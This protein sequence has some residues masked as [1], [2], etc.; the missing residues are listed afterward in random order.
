MK[1]GASP[2]ILTNALANFDRAA[3]LLK[4][5][6]GADLLAV[7]REPKE[8]IELSMGPQGKD[9]SLRRVRGFIV[10]HN[11]ALGPSKGGIRMSEAVTLDDITGL[12][13]EMTWKCALIGVPFG[14]GKSGIVADARSINP[15]DKETIIRSFARNAHRHISPQVYVPAPDMGTNERDMG[16]LKDAIAFSQGVATTRG[17][18]VTGK[19]VILGG[20]PGRRE[21]TGRG[22][23]VCAL[24]ALQ[25]HG[26]DPCKAT[27]IVQGFG[28][29][30]AASA[31]LFAE[32]G[33]KVIAA[34]DITGAVFKADG[35]N[36]PALHKHASSAGGIHGY[37]APGVKTIDGQAMLELPCDVL[38]PAASA[39]Q[40]TIDNAK[41]IR[42]KMIIE[43]ANGPTSVAADE[44]LAG[45]EIPIYPDILAN[46]GGVF[47]SY[48]EYTQETQAEQMS[49]E[50]VR[51]RLTR[52][53]Q[54]RFD[55]VCQ[56][57]RDRKLSLRDAAM[58]L[59]VKTVCEALEA[60][61]R[62]P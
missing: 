13:M 35:L 14:G 40:I 32:A 54:E 59:A 8:R 46:A 60:K 27:A 36:V 9:G 21:A 25:V 5:Q 48:L 10:R 28:N 22:V 49:E 55:A 12:A 19:P 6:F 57:A 43:G 47:V 2:T 34:S 50:A 45:R 20:I 17:C 4:G 7:L 30:G 11:D 29:V 33:V 52:R 3:D 18:Y 39:N 58:V 44:I 62:L 53:M 61:G 37:K 23:V 51:D 16:H 38:I 41:N 26:I 24:K 56:T 1:T 42:A 31:T 15:F